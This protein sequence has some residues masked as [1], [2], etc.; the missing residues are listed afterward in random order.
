MPG[1]AASAAPNSVRALPVPDNAAALSFYVVK[2][3]PGACGD[4]CD[5]WIEADG[6]V[7]NAAAQRFRRFLKQI[8][9]RHLP[10][11]FHSPGG[12]IAQALQIGNM[13]RESNAVA[14]I[15]R[16]VVQDCGFEAQDG[17]VC[18]KLKQSGRELTGELWTR[19][20]VCN[21]ACP[22]MVLGAPNREIAA[23][24][25]LGV[26]S[27]HVIMNFPAEVPS[28]IRVAALDRAMT[29]S[30]ATV[31]GYLRRMGA[32]PGLLTVARSV[33]FEDIHVL[34]RDEIAA[35]GIDR[36]SKV[37][38]PWTFEQFNRG[39][40]YKTLIERP[41]DKT[42][43]RTTRLQLFCINANQ[44]ELHFQRDTLLSGT[45]WGAVTLAF[46][47]AQRSF[48]FPPRHDQNVETWSIRMSVEDVVT[49]ASDPEVD[50]T[51]K[52]TLKGGLP[53]RA[54]HFGTD[55]LRTSLLKLMATCPAGGSVPKLPRP[56]PQMVSPFATRVAWPGR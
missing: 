27:P 50:I 14:R 28:E 16:T 1:A 18:T 11:Y 12:N 55:G 35:F 43:F 49:L 38:T 52:D 5:S 32:E 26:H 30:D 37:E 24:A 4:G 2:G 7:D 40:I 15:G 39:L 47:A 10:I 17:P 42:P 56:Q 33:K 53:L 13:L 46:G 34:T 54:D 44:Y 22:Y 29:R 6:K 3:R 31:S 9:N 51:E 21:S 41:D 48:F 20:A 36:R 25:V 19:G 23:D 45:S 8:G